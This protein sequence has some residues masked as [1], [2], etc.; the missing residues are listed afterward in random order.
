MRTIVRL[1]A[2]LSRII[3]PRS[4]DCFHRDEKGAARNGVAWLGGNE[5]TIKAR[6]SGCAMLLDV[7]L[8]DYIA[9]YRTSFVF[10]PYLSKVLFI[11]LVVLAIDSR[12]NQFQECVTSF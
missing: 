7:L 8:N 4:I 12:Y 1:Q 3:L 9:H 10:A 5:S 6:G 2:S 11:T